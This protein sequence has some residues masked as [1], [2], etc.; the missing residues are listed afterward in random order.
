MTP[1]EPAI[2]STEA[3]ISRRRMLKRIGAGAAVAWTAPIL[4][5]IHTP[6]FAQS[7][8]CDCPPYSCQVPQHCVDNPNCVCAPH[9]G[10]G[11]CL[12]WTGRVSCTACDTDADCPE[13]WACGDIDPDCG[14]GT[15]TCMQTEGCA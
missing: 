10:G 3:G 13:G 6:A 9:H 14:C 15:A 8:S 4:T 12:C 11:P 1:E 5:S 2:E 7:P